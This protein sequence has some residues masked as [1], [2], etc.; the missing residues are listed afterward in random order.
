M[1]KS[2]FQHCDDCVAVNVERID[3]LETQ[4]VCL[5]ASGEMHSVAVNDAGHIFSWG[6]NQ[7]SQLGRQ[8]PSE[9]MSSAPK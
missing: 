1:P 3:G 2:A 4:V 6:D 8:T 7:F 5:V 9:L